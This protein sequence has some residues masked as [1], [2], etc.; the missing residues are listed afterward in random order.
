MAETCAINFFDP[1]FL[2][3]FYSDRGSIGTRST[4]SNVSR[5]GQR[6]VFAFSHV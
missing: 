6:A 5:A 1:A 4:R 3:D 2:F